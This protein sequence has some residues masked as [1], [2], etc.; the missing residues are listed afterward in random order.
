M[1]DLSLDPEELKQGGVAMFAASDGL[2][3]DFRQVAR[4]GRGLADAVDTGVFGG[5]GEVV[6]AV[7]RWEGA[8]VPGLR[9][10]VEELGQFLAVYAVQHVELDAVT[11]EVFAQYADPEVF[12]VDPGSRTT[13]APE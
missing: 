6:Q 1:T 13:P 7:E 10:R 2:Y 8:V 4:E 12:P 3:E 11:A 5:V 9:G